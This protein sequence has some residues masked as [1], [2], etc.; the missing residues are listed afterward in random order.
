MTQPEGPTPSITRWWVSH[1][2]RPVLVYIKC[3]KPKC[4]RK[5]GEIKRDG[6]VVMAL[7]KMRFP[8]PTVSRPRLGAPHV[9]ALDQVEARRAEH[10]L[11]RY[12]TDAGQMEVMK[13]RRDL[14][15]T[16]GPLALWSSYVCPEHGEL[17]A[18]RDHLAAFVARI[19]G[20]TPEGAALTYFIP[21]DVE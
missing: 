8:E 2:D 14:P 7:R 6:D 20:D 15:D 16:V 3:G 9:G 13:Q 18:D 21:R 19:H 11:K 12:G 4:G 5:I 17:A 1:A 10:V